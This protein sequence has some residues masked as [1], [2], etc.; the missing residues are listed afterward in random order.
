[1]TRSGAEQTRLDQERREYFDSLAETGD[2]DSYSE[3]DIRG[4]NEILD[5][6][7]FPYNEPLRVLDCGCGTGRS[8]EIIAKR[9][10]QGSRIIGVDY[11][12]LM[13]ARAKQ[14]R[15][16]V[17]GGIIEFEVMNCQKL[18]YEDGSFDWVVALECFPHFAN[19]DTALGEFYRILKD[20]GFVAILHR[21]S[22]TDINE[23]H[24]SVGGPVKNDILPDAATF[25]LLMRKLGFWVMV[26][27]D[28][29][30]GFRLMAR[31]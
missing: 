15:P 1:M 14:L 12:P 17:N 31:K 3:D 24:A 20:G 8:T 25:L 6:I 19:Q 29:N 2:F 13:I 10:G 23:F 11:S 26:Y 7:H 27:I 5:D 9:L 16:S 28:D 4:I 22:S 21:D 30:D 18:T